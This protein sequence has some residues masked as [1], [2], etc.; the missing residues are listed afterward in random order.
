MEKIIEILK[1]INWD[2]LDSASKIN[3][4]EEN[5]SNL[6]SEDDKTANEAYWKFDNV[7]VLQGDLYESSFYLVPFL[8]ETLKI[9]ENLE[10]ILELLFQIINGASDKNQ[11]VIYDINKDP[12]LY[13][14][15]NNNSNLKE[16]LGEAIKSAIYKQKD[17][18]LKIMVNT[19]NLQDFETLINIF[20]NLKKYNIVK[21]IERIIEN[22]Y[23]SK[24]KLEIYNNDYKED[25][26]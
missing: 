21:D 26:I 17:I 22:N 20:F 10:Y 1:T 12:F 5:F 8:I 15:P 16:P 23:L 7:V 4:I 3:N 9:S 18:L 14:F 2:K 24:E 6:I 13:Y 11:Y 25:F 19:N